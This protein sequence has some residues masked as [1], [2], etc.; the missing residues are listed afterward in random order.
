ML[1][2]A[3]IA[4]T[5]CAES[6][7]EYR[8]YEKSALKTYRRGKEDIPLKPGMELRK[9]GGIN[10]LIPEGSKVYERNGL[11]FIETPEEFIARRIKEM[12]GRLEAMENKVTGLNEEV[13]TLKSKI[14]AQAESAEESETA[15]ESKSVIETTEENA[16]DGWPEKEA[17]EQEEE[18]GASRIGVY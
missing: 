13:E 16:Y 2:F 11:Y 18:E 8:G 5:V 15:E 9:I 1:A 17:Q 7:T 4:Q 3:F 6:D 12:G 10:L 14:A